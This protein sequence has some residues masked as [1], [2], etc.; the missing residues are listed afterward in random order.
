MRAMHCIASLMHRYLFR[1]PKQTQT[2]A[3][4]V[5]EF[6]AFFGLG[7]EIQALEPSPPPAPVDDLA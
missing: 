1:L 4:S 5:E 6:V 3:I 2:G 7:T